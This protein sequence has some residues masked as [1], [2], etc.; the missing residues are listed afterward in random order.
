L[1]GILKEQGQTFEAVEK[2]RF[3][4]DAGERLGLELTRG[5]E[6]ERTSLRFTQVKNRGKIRQ[7]NQAKT[8]TARS[9]PEVCDSVLFRHRSVRQQ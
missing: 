1:E 7:K 4:H 2:N 9:V 6:L 5:D 8:G 3:G